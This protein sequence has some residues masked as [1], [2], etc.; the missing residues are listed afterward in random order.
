MWNVGMAL[1]SSLEEVRIH[2]HTIHKSQVH[3]YG[4]VCHTAASHYITDYPLDFLSALQLV[5]LTLTTTMATKTT[6]I[7]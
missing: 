7:T 6:R 1:S 5:S 3:E 2:T 4:V